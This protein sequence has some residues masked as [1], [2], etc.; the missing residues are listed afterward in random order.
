MLA[1]E[2]IWLDGWWH[3]KVID[4]GVMIHEAFVKEGGSLLFE[5]VIRD[6][7][8]AGSVAESYGTLPKDTTGENLRN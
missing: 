3:Y 2:T 5:D 8:A 6:H 4:S 7:H 1:I